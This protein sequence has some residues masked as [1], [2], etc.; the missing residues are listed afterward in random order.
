[1]RLE[2]RQMSQGGGGGASLGKDLSWLARGFPDP[3]LLLL[4]E[5][6]NSNYLSKCLLNTSYMPV[7]VQ[8]PEDTK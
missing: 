3:G 5:D 8:G 1:M 4:S 7:T 2:K 6:Y